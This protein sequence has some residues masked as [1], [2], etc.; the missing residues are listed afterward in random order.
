MNISLK[1]NNF[2]SKIKSIN[3]GGE[4]ISLQS[5]KVMGIINLTPDSF[6]D[7]AALQSEK[8]IL[9]KVEKH[10]SEGATFI[11][12]G[13]VSTRPGSIAISELEELERLL[14]AIKSIKSTFPNAILS[15]DTYRSKIADM[16]IKEGVNIINDISSGEFDESMF[17]VIAKHKV[18]Y[19]MMH[20]QG[21]PENMQQ[22]PIYQNVTK[23]IIYFFSQKLEIIRKLGINDIILD[24][25]FG[26]GKTI[27]HNY[28]ILSELSLFKFAECPIL[29]GISRKSM[30]YKLL[31]T[32]ANEAL[33]GTSVANTIALIN[34]ADILRVHDVKEAVETIK[35]LEALNINK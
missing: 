31:N 30:I 1:N 7:G 3:C 25:G 12:I 5:A 35:I 21:S 17:K 26:F 28:Q 16:A 32:N 2:S 27:E 33:N 11:D 29:I 13:A 10:L 8:A 24:P 19:I 34:G 23:E 9:D 15:V 22:N 18:P 20:T 4:L 14:P 6:Y